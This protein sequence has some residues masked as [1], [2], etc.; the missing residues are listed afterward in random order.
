MDWIIMFI[1]VF[2]NQLKLETMES[3]T[4]EFC[5]YYKN[6]KQN[7]IDSTLIP[8]CDNRGVALERV[9]RLMLT[10][11]LRLSKYHYTLKKT[12]KVKEYSC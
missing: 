8:N 5:L 4:Y 1:F 2:R 7:M 6:D 3:Y 10:Q 9:K 11:G 12:N